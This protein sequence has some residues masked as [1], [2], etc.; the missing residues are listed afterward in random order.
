MEKIWMLPALIA[1]LSGGTTDAFTKK[2]LQLH[3]EYIIGW[4]RQLVVVLLLLPGL[5]FIPI[6][7]LGE[8]FYLACFLALPLEVI[9][10]ISYMRA[11]KI[12]PLSLTIPFL[13]LT[14]ISLI[15]IPYV[16]L[17]EKVSLWGGFGILLIALGSYTLNLKE[18]RRGVLAPIQAIGKE[19]GSLL[20]IVVAL[21]YGFT[22]TFGKQAINAS[23]ALFF[24]ATYNVAFFI[25]LSP[26]IFMAVRKRAQGR[27]VKEALRSSILPGFFAAVTV[28]FYTAAIGLTNVAYANTVC[29][30]S[31]LVAVVY[32]HFL[33]KESGFGERLAGAALM[34]VGFMI[35]ALGQN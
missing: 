27:L 32:G 19:P 22:N 16:M 29:R 26:V 15:I 31:L 18:V 35:I 34:L 24:A 7:P 12:S 21:I 2:A 25:V 17:G 9:A 13:S 14:P 8:A 5:L 23:S 11:I 6:P 30:L 1:A 28:L 20:M 33:F 10:Y 4:I 3:D